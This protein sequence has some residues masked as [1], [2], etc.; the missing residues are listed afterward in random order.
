VHSTTGAT[1]A[2]LLVVLAILGLGLG[3]G[4]LYLSPIEAPLQSAATLVEGLCRQARLSAIATTSAYRV[5]PSTDRRLVAERAS[6]CSATSW[7]PDGATTVDLP[8]GVTVETTAWSVCFG[9]RGVSSDNQQ[10]RLQHAQLGS[11]GVEVLLG[12]TTRIV[13]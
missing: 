5:L 9:S 6:S 12:G 10:I 11:I 1:L 13:E 8:K 7:T 4:S 3:I 2:E